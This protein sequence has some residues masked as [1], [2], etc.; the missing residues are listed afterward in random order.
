MLTKINIRN[1]KALKETGDI[2]LD[3]TVVLIGANN[4]GKTTAL[5]AFALWQLGLTKWIEKR[6]LGASGKKRTGVP[7]NR[8]DIFAI[9]VRHNKLMWTDLFSQQSERDEQGKIKS[10]KDVNIEIIAEGITQ[11]KSW[12]CGLEFEYRDEEVIY[13][14]PLKTMNDNALLTRP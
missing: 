1:F 12:K 7:I 3:E 11:G 13:A 10:T 6:A 9:P 14:R 2:P 5:Q 4:T 8:K